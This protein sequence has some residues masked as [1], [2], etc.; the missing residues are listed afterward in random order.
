MQQLFKPPPDVESIQMGDY[1]EVLIGEHIGKCGIVR[2]LPKGADSLWF[3]DGTL[4]IPVPI[5][6][7]WW[8]HLPHLQTLQYTKDRGYDVKPGDVVR[9]VR[10]PEYLTKGVVQSIDFPKARL[11]LLSDIDHSLVDVHM[12][13]Q[14]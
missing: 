2:W 12:Q 1:I 4:N 14:L 7:I 6:F 13:R 10:G 9:V 11:T 8:S 3:Q 5:S